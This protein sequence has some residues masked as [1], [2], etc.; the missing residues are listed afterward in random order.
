M[1]L[2]AAI[3]YLSVILVLVLLLI[4]AGHGIMPRHRWYTEFRRHRTKK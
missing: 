2:I 1:A 4:F 3:A